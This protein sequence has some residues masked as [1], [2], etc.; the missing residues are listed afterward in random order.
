MQLRNQ[1]ITDVIFGEEEV[2][3]DRIFCLVEVSIIGGILT[4]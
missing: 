3:F 4:H 2:R 1:Y